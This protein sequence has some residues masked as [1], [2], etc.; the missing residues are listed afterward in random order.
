MTMP[1]ELQQLLG[2]G[3][4]AAGPAAPPSHIPIPG[5][6]AGGPGD[7]AGVPGPDNPKVEQLVTQATDLLRQAV[8]LEHDPPDKAFLS[9]LVARAHKFLGDQQALVDKATGA[10][11]GAKL[12][13]KATPPTGGGQGIGGY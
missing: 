8:N 5:A 10:G 3:P 4:A 7:N 6:A 9:D 2:G 1:P 11:P 13:R 12:V